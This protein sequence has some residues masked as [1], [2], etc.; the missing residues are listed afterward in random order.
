MHEGSSCKEES[1]ALP[2][3]TLSYAVYEYSLRENSISKWPDTAAS[4]TLL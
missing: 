1:A 4:K 3:K 2:V